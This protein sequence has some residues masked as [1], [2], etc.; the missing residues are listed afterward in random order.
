M[1]NRIFSFNIWH[2]KL[3]FEVFSHSNDGSSFISFF[4][5]LPNKMA[6]QKGMQKNEKYSV[7]RI[8]LDNHQAFRIQNGQLLLIQMNH[9][10]SF[11]NPWFLFNAK[12][13]KRNPIRYPS[14]SFHSI[15][16]HSWIHPID[17]WINITIK[18]YHSW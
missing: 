15:Q 8:T 1:F 2:A 7:E 14:H 6:T 13:K 17:H 12:K 11:F 4:F 3:W 16:W 10:V 18:D 5:S 9:S